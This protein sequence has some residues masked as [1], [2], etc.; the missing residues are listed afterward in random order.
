MRIFC[1]D[2]FLVALVENVSSLNA[3]GLIPSSDPVISGESL[4]VTKL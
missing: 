4:L 2:G 1:F 3:K